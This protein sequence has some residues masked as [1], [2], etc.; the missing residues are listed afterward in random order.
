MEGAQLHLLSPKH[1]MLSSY[2]MAQ[3]KN[4]ASKWAPYLNV[5]PTSLSYFPIFYTKEERTLL[6]GSPFLSI[7][8]IKFE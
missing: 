8:V 5:L 6:Q 3:R 4:P 1:S 7:F 2:I